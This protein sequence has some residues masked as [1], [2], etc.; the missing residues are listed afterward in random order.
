MDVGVG[1]GSEK[2]VLSGNY[3]C[4]G[5]GRGVLARGRGG[6]RDGEDGLR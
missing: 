4:C 5:G 6:G 2:V 1:P 3:L